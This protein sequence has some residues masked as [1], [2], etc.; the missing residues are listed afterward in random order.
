MGDAALR[1]RE[2]RP[3]RVSVSRSVILSTLLVSAA[4]AQDDPI[5]QKC[6]QSK[7]KAAGKGCLC[8]HKEWAKSGAKG[9][10][11]DFSR[12]EERL[13]SALEK[14]ETQATSA[15][16]ACF[17]GESSD[18]IIAAIAAAADKTVT[19]TSR[20][21]ISPPPVAC[22]AVDKPVQYSGGNYSDYFK[23]VAPA[24]GDTDCTDEKTLF[25]MATVILTQ[26]K[27]PDCP[28]GEKGCDEGIDGP[29][30]QLEPRGGNCCIKAD[31]TDPTK[32]STFE[33]SCGVCVSS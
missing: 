20:G 27:C 32:S 30:L 12:C 22:D 25:A 8:F 4:V 24:A 11:P 28:E 7:L 29:S 13:A 26:F 10:L 2:G 3:M 16:G 19:Q 9:E 33:I 6:S 5:G 14:A 23:C 15:G 17:A 21:T 18:A 1:R 31:A